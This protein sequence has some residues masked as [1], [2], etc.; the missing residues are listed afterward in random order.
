MTCDDWRLFLSRQFLFDSF[1]EIKASNLNLDE[2]ELWYLFRKVSGFLFTKTYE[3]TEGDV[4]NKELHGRLLWATSV[5]RTYPKLW[6]QPGPARL[7]DSSSGHLGKGRNQLKKG[8]PINQQ[9]VSHGHNLYNTDDEMNTET[10]ARDLNALG[11]NGTFET[12]GEQDRPFCLSYRCLP[13]S[14]PQKYG[15]H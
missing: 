1:H 10:S 14:L 4:N 12:S 15:R 13:T 6:N 5:M 7:W 2:E 11:R 8:K 9:T 3:R